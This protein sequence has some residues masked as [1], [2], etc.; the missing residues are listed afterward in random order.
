MFAEEPRRAASAIAV[1]LHGTAS[2][3]A[4][5]RLLWN[6]SE[7]IPKVTPATGDTDRTTPPWRADGVTE[8]RGSRDD[9]EQVRPAP[10]SHPVR[11][12]TMIR[13]YMEPGVLLVQSG[14]DHTKET[15]VAPDAAEALSN[16]AENGHELVLVTSERVAL[17]GPG[18]ATH[19]A[20]IQRC[21]IRTRD[22]NAAV[23]EILA[24]E[25][26]APVG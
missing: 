7:A 4:V 9:G 20:T 12:T 21:D 5:F 24:R 19:K 22:L 6:A 17:V 23:I 26:M 14:A 25:A 11:S 10:R 18:P 15:R 8:G 13:V 1:R 2:D 3:G 16:L